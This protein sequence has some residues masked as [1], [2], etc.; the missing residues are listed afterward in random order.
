MAASPPGES[1]AYRAGLAFLEAGD[2]AE[3]ERRLRRALLVTPDSGAVLLALATAQL[4]LGRPEDALSHLV[5]LPDDPEAGYLAGLA[6]IR[7]NRY[8]EA[9]ESLI[10]V[11]EARPDLDKA[12]FHLGNCLWLL[13]RPSDLMAL[14]AERHERFG[15]GADFVFELLMPSIDAGDF[16]GFA[17]LA[18]ATQEGHPASAVVQFLAATLHAAAGRWDAAHDLYREAVAMAPPGLFAERML[19]PCR[20]LAG[21]DWDPAD[22]PLP[23]IPEMTLQEL[24]PGDGPVVVAACDARYCSLFADYFGRTLSGV[25]PECRLH[26]HVIDPD[27]ESLSVLAGLSDFL[28]LGTS[29]EWSGEWRGA[30]Y[31]S[32]ARFLRAGALLDAYGTDLVIADVDAEVLRDPRDLVTAASVACFQPRFPTAVFPWLGCSAALVVL[33]NDAEGHHFADQVA[34][35]IGAHLDRGLGWFIDQIALHFVG[36]VRRAP[37]VADLQQA[38]G[39]PHEAFCRPTGD[40]ALKQKLRAEADE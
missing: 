12:W 15:D 30:G 40:L 37:P 5:R 19:P 34:R 10:S 31:F 25:A 7:V 21:T 6:L 3:A 36:R 4:N 1:S 26:L 8:E 20:L 27:E 39:L 35:Y 23:P 32:A 33:R 2:A 29:F 11:I 24:A 14:A 13:G 9:T 16:S 22:A 18:S 28:P 17:A 38:T